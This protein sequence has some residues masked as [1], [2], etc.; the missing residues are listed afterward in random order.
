MDK[1]FITMDNK[2]IWCVLYGSA[3]LSYAWNFGSLAFVFLLMQIVT[4][5]LLAMFY[6]PSVTL[7][8]TS[9]MDINNEVYYVDG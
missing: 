6:N 5:I 7:A 2:I 9:I 1:K 3:N 4:G 8:F